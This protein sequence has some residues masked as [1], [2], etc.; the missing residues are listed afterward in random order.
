MSNKQNDR[1]NEAKREAEAEDRPRTAPEQNRYAEEIGRQVN[2]TIYRHQFATTKRSQPNISE[3][4]KEKAN[5]QYKLR[6]IGAIEL[7]DITQEKAEELV[8]DI[9]NQ[10]RQAI[11]QAFEK[12]RPEVKDCLPAFPHKKTPVSALRLGMEMYEGVL[13]S[14][15]DKYLNG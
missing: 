14:N 15:Q 2:G 9:D 8:E 11:R 1:F 6:V 4:E 5:H 12:T 10:I 7:Y 3:E 13:K